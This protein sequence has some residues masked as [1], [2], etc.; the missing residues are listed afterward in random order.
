MLREIEAHAGGDLV[1]FDGDEDL[2]VAVVADVRAPVRLRD[3]HRP[4]VRAR[5]SLAD[6]PPR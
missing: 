3:H 4:A 6:M 1:A 5:D 2:R